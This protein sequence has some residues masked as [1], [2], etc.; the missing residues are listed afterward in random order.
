ML[1]E[2]TISQTDIMPVGNVVSE[3]AEIL[4]TETANSEG[5]KKSPY[6]IQRWAKFYDLNDYQMI[7]FL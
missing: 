5:W 3:S 2:T 7:F 6:S 1:K 4:A